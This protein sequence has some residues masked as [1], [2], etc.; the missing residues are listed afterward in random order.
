MLVKRVVAARRNV[1]V[2]H[3]ARGAFQQGVKILVSTL[4]L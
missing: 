1:T 4:H 2:F 3:L